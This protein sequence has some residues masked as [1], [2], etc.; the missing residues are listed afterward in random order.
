MNRIQQTQTAGTNLPQQYTPGGVNLLSDLAPHQRN[1]LESHISNRPFEFSIAPGGRTS[2]TR[3]SAGQAAVGSS[4]SGGGPPGGSGS[5]GSSSSGTGT[6]SPLGR[7]E[8]PL[9]GLAGRAGAPRSIDLS[10]LSPMDPP[11]EG[12]L[13]GS[14]HPDGSSSSKAG[15]TGTPGVGAGSATEKGTGK[16]RQAGGASDFVKKL[17]KCALP[18]PPSMSPQSMLTALMHTG[19]SKKISTRTLSCGEVAATRSSSR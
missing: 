11:A 12:D 3:S 9:G 1:Q 15:G 10:M 7:P 14:T 6:G 2:L 17:Y 4:S 8:A 5:G 16:G 19:C 18:H 13:P